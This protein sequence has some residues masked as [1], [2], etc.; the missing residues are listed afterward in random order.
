[1]FMLFVNVLYFVIDLFEKIW[2][3]YGCE[4]SC[5]S[6]CLIYYVKVGNVNDC[7]MFRKLVVEFFNWS[8]L[9]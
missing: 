5:L 6:I 8:W 4:L 9:V 2:C 3:M 7:M 1:M